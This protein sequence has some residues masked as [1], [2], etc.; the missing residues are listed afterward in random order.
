M[1]GSIGTMGDIER[2][3]SRKVPERMDLGAGPQ[4]RIAEKVLPT[5]MTR[6]DESAW[7][8]YQQLDKEIKAEV[9]ENKIEIRK[10]PEDN[11]TPADQTQMSGLVRSLMAVTNNETRNPN[12]KLEPYRLTKHISTRPEE[13]IKVDQ[14]IRSKKNDFQDLLRGLKMR[15]E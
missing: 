7:Q 10:K 15:S 1:Q 4:V 2:E 13:S 8:A 12:T 3:Q 6:N 11:F 9:E 5:A 14:S